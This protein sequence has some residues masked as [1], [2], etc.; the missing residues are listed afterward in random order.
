MKCP[1][2]GYIS[3]D[4]NLTCPKCNKDISREQKKLNLPAFP[5]APPSLL[6]ALTGQA[7]ESQ[8][9]IQVGDFR[10]T[11]R[12]D[13]L[14]EVEVAGTDELEDTGSF[15]D[16]AEEVEIELETETVSEEVEKPVVPGLKEEKI[17]EELADTEV[18]IKD[19]DT[20]DDLELEDLSLSLEE[21]TFGSSTIEKK[22]IDTSEVATSEIEKVSATE[23]T[24]EFNF[25]LELE[26]SEETKS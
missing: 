26:D 20:Q 21:E 15:M 5:P 19:F 7:S 10:D 13:H 14:P 18:N 9:G 2:C 25:E 4:Y 6:G 17:I 11:V 23:E 22:P 12:I 1:K 16:E 24:D 8:M 3:F